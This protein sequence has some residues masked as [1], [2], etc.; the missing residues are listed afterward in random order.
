MEL[1]ENVSN[2]PSFLKDSTDFLNKLNSIPQ[3]LPYNTIMLCLDV[4]VLYPSVPLEGAKRAC[5][6]KRTHNNLPTDNTLQLIDIVLE[7]NI[8]SFNNNHYV[9]TY[10]QMVRQ[11][12]LNWTCIT[13]VPIWKNGTE[14]FCSIVINIRLATS[15]TSTMSGGL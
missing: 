4:K 10:K 13:H 12:N 1:S 14:N 2:L 6:N 3:P 15:D 8:F 5:R 7:N 11:Y 9:Q